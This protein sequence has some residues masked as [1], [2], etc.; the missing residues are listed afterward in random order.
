MA[1]R[2]PVEPNIALGDHCVIKRRLEKHKN[3]KC[4]NNNRQ[5]A[6]EGL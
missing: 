1:S 6:L 2:V 4:G 3:K 5:E